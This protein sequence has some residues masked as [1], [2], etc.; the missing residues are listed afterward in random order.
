VDISPACNTRPVVLSSDSMIISI[1]GDKPEPRLLHRTRDSDAFLGEIRFDP[2]TGPVVQIANGHL[3]RSFG[4]AVNRRLKHRQYFHA[5]FQRPGVFG[6][7][8]FLGVTPMSR[9]DPSV[10]ECILADKEL[11]SG[12]YHGFRVTPKVDQE[13]GDAGPTLRPDDLTT[14]LGDINK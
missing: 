4:G 1:Y 3:R 12:T 6:P 9:T 2:K 11:W 8:Q 14:L 13:A 7:I 5:L 10:M